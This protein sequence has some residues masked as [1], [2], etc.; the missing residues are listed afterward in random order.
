ML[1]FPL[2]AHVHRL[3]IIRSGSGLRVVPAQAA[4]D[5]AAKLGEKAAKI[6][7]KINTSTV[8]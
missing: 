5:D 2:P 8:T 1:K 4:V 3:G 6:K 7:A